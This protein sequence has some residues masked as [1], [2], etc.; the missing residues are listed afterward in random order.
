LVRGVT[1]VDEVRAA[2][3]RCLNEIISIHAI[4]SE[5]EAQFG[6]PINIYIVVYI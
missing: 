1:R 3:N 6:S 4:E 5:M 2:K